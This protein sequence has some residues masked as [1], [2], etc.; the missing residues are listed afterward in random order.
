MTRASIT[1]ASLW[2]IVNRTHSSTRVDS[3]TEYRL[4]NTKY[5]I[6]YICFGGRCERWR[7]LA[8]VIDVLQG[9]GRGRVHF[10]SECVR[11]RERERERV[12]EW[13]RETVCEWVS[14]RVNELWIFLTV[15]SLMYS[16]SHHGVN[17]WRRRWKKENKKCVLYHVLY[18]VV[19]RSVRRV[20]RDFVLFVIAA[21][22][23]QV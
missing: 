19:G 5:W 23:S 17:R 21:V 2:L 3:N 8:I 10:D 16:W 14:E 13:G 18:L 11:E 4:Q 6:S 15:L 20:C 12:S 1:F 7:C 22:V 9:R